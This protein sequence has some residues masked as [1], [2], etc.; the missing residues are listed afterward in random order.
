MLSLYAARQTNPTTLP[1][2]Y[3]DGLATSITAVI[4]DGGVPSNSAPARGMV[5]GIQ[6]WVGVEW[7][8]RALPVLL[9]LGFSD[10]RPPR[11]GGHSVAPLYW[12][13]SEGGEKA[14][15]IVVAAVFV[16]WG[17][18]SDESSL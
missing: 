7:A 9:Q 4:R 14:V 13:G 2:A 16:G 6:I 11:H 15:E 18:G 5:L 8:W 1:H 3:M 17:A 12:T 10:A